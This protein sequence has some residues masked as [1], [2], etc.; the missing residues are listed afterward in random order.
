M[1]LIQILET[2]INGYFNEQE[3]I[4]KIIYKKSVDE[5]RITITA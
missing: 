5:D 1:K 4:N 3:S 2:I